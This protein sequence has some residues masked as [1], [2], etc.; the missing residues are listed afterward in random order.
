MTEHEDDDEC[1]IEV[2]TLTTSSCYSNSWTLKNSIRKLLKHSIKVAR[3][4]VEYLMHQQTLL[5]CLTAA[6]TKRMMLTA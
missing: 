2:Q 4:K 3:D 5:L 6:S 1:R